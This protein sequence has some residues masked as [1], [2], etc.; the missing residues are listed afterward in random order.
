MKPGSDLS[1]EL[2]YLCDVILIGEEWP[3]LMDGLGKGAKRLN[4]HAS[5]PNLAWWS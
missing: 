2:G 4:M 3:L 1:V 5:S